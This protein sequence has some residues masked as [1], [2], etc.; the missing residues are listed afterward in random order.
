MVNKQK[1]CKIALVSISMI[2]I[3]VNITGAES[4]ADNLNHLGCSDCDERLRSW[5]SMI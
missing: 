1:L 5:L 4:F 2:L 3:L